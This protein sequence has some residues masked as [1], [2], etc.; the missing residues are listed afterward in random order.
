[1]NI[2]IVSSSLIMSFMVIIFMAKLVMFLLLSWLGLSC[3][4][5]KIYNAHLFCVLC[6]VWCLRIQ[7]IV[8]LMQV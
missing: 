1:M 4:L 2:G 7:F 3:V 6:A 8:T 5:H